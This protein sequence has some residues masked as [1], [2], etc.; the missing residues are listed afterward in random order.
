MEENL[1]WE[2]VSDAEEFDIAMDGVEEF[3]DYEVMA[4]VEKCLFPILIVTGLFLNI[5]ALVIL[6]RRSLWLHHEAYIYLIAILIN[7]VAQLG[8][9]YVPWWLAL[10]HDT[11]HVA[12]SSEIVCKFWMLLTRLVQSSGWFQTAMLCN[13]DVRL[14]LETTDRRRA[15]SDI[16]RRCCTLRGTLVSVA[17]LLGA[18]I[19]V[20]FW[21]FVKATLQ[22]FGGDVRICY[23]GDMFMRTNVY[24]KLALNCLVNYIPVIVLTPM[25]GI[26]IV[27]SMNRRLGFDFSRVDGEA[28]G[29]GVDAGEPGKLAL[30]LALVLFVLRSPFHLMHLLDESRIFHS[31][32]AYFAVYVFSL[33]HPVA[34]PIFCFAVPSRF[35]QEAKAMA[36]RCWD[37]TVER[38]RR[39]RRRSVP[40][41]AWDCG[42][43][44]V[45]QLD[46]NFDTE[47]DV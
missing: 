34:V 41:V 29:G 19:V 25:L 1:T 20:N 42:S 8:A 14:R 15:C 22:H 2:Q 26:M 37:Y 11:Y 43:T 44:L 24:V 40:P 18:S 5:V 46:A 4:S 7:D 3:I 17:L 21:Y 45:L 32:R 47:T 38:C 6:V 9:V 16:C 13:V 23:A 10:F 30:W 28:A 35:R 33:L 12:Y 27:I 31:Y 39:R 36:V